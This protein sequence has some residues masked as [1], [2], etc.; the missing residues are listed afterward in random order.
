M[1]RHAAG[2]PAI[3]ACT[4]ATD[5]KHAIWHMPLGSNP[6][7]EKILA[8][9]RSKSLQHLGKHTGGLGRASLTLFGRRTDH[10]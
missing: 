8:P 2:K 1:L 6:V 4:R 9:F 5:E 7:R 3:R 10:P